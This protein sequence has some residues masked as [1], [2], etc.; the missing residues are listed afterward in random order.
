MQVTRIMQDIDAYLIPIDSP[1]AL[2]RL[3]TISVVYTDLDGTLLAPGGKLLS[4]HAGAPS[5]ALA[6]TLTN[7]KRAGIRVAIATGRGAAQGREFNR[8]FDLD[9]FIC[10]MG[11]VVIQGVGYKSAKTYLLD[12]WE[13][14]VISEGL[15]PGI[16][17]KGAT[18]Y[19]LIEQS[20]V[21]QRLTELCGDM[22]R[23]YPAPQREVTSALWGNVEGL[24]VEELLDKEILPLQLIDN[25]ILNSPPGTLPV[26]KEVH[27][28]HLM[29]KGTSKASGVAYDIKRRNAEKSETLSIGDSPEDLRMAD[30]TGE[31]VIM[32][33]ALK[34]AAVRDLIV[35][36]GVA[37]QKTL[38]T[39]LPTA[40][41]W[42]EFAQALL[43]A[44]SS[45]ISSP[46]Q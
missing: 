36:R 39:T 45:S 41:G 15:A 46:I 20:G 44:K 24:A 1:E 4:D 11:S 35:E 34:S 13:N 32:Q 28:Y 8:L 17:P 30:V 12:S 40:D 23:F 14:V 7:L 22:L 27:I 2:D 29:P 9:T 5:F 19:E 33:N 18:P 10:E 31:F 42:V 37:G 38:C 6:A 43:K 3:R 16:L 25:G 21:L 26:D